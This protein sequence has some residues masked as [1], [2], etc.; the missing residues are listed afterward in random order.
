MYIRYD[1]A[2][3]P[4]L[5]SEAQNMRKLIRYWHNI[6]NMNRHRKSLYYYY[7]HI[8]LYKY[9]NGLNYKQPSYINYFCIVNSLFYSLTIA[10]YKL[11]R[12][13]NFVNNS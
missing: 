4:C 12:Y 7:L 8:L 10:N 3:P 11:T 2:T 13:F 9:S 5:V 1:L 6:I